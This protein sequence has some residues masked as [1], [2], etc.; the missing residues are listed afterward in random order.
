MRSVT[1]A[2]P[3]L[4]L[5]QWATIGERIKAR[6]KRK[7]ATL[8]EVSLATGIPL[9]TLSKVENSQMSLNIGKL[10]KLCEALDVDVMQLVAPEETPRTPV[11]VTGRRSITRAG[12]VETV[13]T[14]RAAYHHHGRDF[15]HKKMMPAVIEIQTDPAP[16]MIRHRGEEFIYVLDGVIEIHTEFYEPTIL[17]TGESIYLDSSMAHNVRAV[18]GPAR[19]LNVMTSQSET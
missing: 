17:R 9:S 4:T 8:K 18:D 2:A 13:V 12:D 7:K 1:S 16:D 5:G 14:N 10:L 6:R 15:S 3:E 19:I 11:T